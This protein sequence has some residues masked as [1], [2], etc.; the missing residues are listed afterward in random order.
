[1]KRRDFIKGSAALALA[2][3]TANIAKAIDLTGNNKADDP[4]SGKLIA[5][6]PLL[7]NYAET[8]MGVAFAVNALATGPVRCQES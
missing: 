1:M 3:G 2:A 7:E 8:S 6:A 4:I 5:S